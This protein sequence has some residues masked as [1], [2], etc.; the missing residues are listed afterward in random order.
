MVEN[1][2]IEVYINFVKTIKFPD[3]E[4]SGCCG[5]MPVW[6]KLQLKKYR[7]EGWADWKKRRLGWLHICLLQSH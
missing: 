5:N 2:G 1:S 3:T 6:M 4:Y 7:K